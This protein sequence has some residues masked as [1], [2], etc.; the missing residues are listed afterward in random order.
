MNIE[1][2]KV[3]WNEKNIAVANTRRGYEVY[4]QITSNNEDGTSF[5]YWY[6]LDCFDDLDEAIVF[7][8]G[9]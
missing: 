8:K 7:A 9:L 6:S 2:N 1:G 5:R 3:V 4:K